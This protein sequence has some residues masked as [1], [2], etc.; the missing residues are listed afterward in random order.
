[1]KSTSKCQIP[2]PDT[3][4]EEKGIHLQCGIIGKEIKHPVCTGGQIGANQPPDGY[5]ADDKREKAWLLF[6]AV[7]ILRPTA[8]YFFAIIHWLITHPAP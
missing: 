6:L 8:I 5:S 1:M 7:V 3:N 2:N 4:T